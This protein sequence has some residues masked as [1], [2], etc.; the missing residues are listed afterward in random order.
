MSPNDLNLAIAR[1]CGLSTDGLQ[2]LTLEVRCGRWPV[3]RALYVPE[4]GD[5]LVRV[6]VASIE[7]PCGVANASK[8]TTEA[9]KN[10]T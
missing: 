9:D 2:S 5:E 8:P 7:P 6:L 1:A 10:G 4:S 3:V